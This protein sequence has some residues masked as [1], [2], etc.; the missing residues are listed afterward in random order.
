MM[1]DLALVIFYV[2]GNVNGI[3]YIAGYQRLQL[4]A[5]ELC[6]DV[7]EIVHEIER[8]LYL[9]RYTRCKLSQRCHFL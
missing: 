5:D 3:V 9:M 2:V 1:I 4:F 6:I 7:G 8:V